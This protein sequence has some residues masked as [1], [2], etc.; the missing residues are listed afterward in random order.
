MPTAVARSLEGVTCPVACGPRFGLVNW[1][2]GGSPFPLVRRRAAWVQYGRLQGWPCRRAE[3]GGVPCPRHRPL[4][5][6]RGGPGAGRAAAA[7]DALRAAAVLA[8]RALAGGERPAAHAAAL[9][10]AVRT[11][12]GTSRRLLLSEHHLLRRRESEFLRR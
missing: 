1:V 2:P 11:A 7:T 3:R 4:G 5:G 6:G 9:V 10:D 12:P 8:P